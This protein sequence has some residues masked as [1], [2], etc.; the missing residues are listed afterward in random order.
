[1]TLDPYFAEK[2]SHIVGLSESDLAEPSAMAR[3]MSYFTDSLPWELPD[4]VTVE[5]HSVQGAV[6]IPVRVYR[7]SEEVSAPLVWLH[8]G[9]FSFGDLDMPEAHIVAAELA[10]RAGS[11]VVSVDYRL[12]TE[13]VRFPLPVEDVLSVWEWVC[14]FS[15]GIAPAIGGA[16]AGAA[17]AL[18]AAL[19]LRTNR[20]VAPR[21]VLLAYP[22]VHFPTPALDPDVAEVMA[23]L[24]PLMR[25]TPRA[26]ESM[27]STYVGRLSNLPP[28]AMPGAAD[29]SDLS[30]VTV[31]VSELDDL[32]ASGEL[33]VR[34]LAEAG[35]PTRTRLSQGMPHGHLNRVPS[36]P[37]VGRSIDF[38]AE[39][40]R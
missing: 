6:L 19:R 23:E 34:Q 10:A 5:N 15:G 26:V 39:A 12:A 30:P 33:L 16:S 22:F 28:D 2:A 40:L 18:T 4:G 3:F 8:G 7:P 17:I 14:T 13:S 38:L 24:P 9:G 37:E 35:V 1:M 27:V 21:A 32:R 11:L 20:N 29:L 36:I 31:L 25:F